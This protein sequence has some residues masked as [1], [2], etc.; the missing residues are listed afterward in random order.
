MK[1]FSHMTQTCVTLVTSLTLAITL[2]HHIKSHSH[3]DHLI[4]GN[5]S[6]DRHHSRL[7]SIVVIWITPDTNMIQWKSLELNMVVS[8]EDWVTLCLTQSERSR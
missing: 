3:N 8:S 6:V 4:D 1:I 5:I 2:N 7:R